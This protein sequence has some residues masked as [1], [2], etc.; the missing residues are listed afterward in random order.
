MLSQSIELNFRKRKSPLEAFFVALKKWFESR[1]F[2]GC[3]FVRELVEL[4][5]SCHP[6]WQ[7]SADHKKNHAMLQKFT[8]ESDGDKSEEMAPALSLLVDGAV[9]TALMEQSSPPADVAR[10]ARW[11]LISTFQLE[12]K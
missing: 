12:S 2:R 3:L 4:P 11:E 7:F 9:V 8:S 6:M 5:D 10:D 1:G